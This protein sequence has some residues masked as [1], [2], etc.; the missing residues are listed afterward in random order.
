MEIAV[1]AL[2][3]ICLVQSIIHYKERRDLYSR[4]M[5]RDLG[6]YTASKDRDPPKSRNY[7]KTSLRRG[8]ERIHQGRGE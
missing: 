4:I 1:I 8:I 2:V 5:A 6:D 3:V 7:L